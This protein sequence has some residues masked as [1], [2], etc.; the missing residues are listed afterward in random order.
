MQADGII[1]HG[2]QFTY[3]ARKIVGGE[4][5]CQFSG[6][7]RLLLAERLGRLLQK[8]VKEEGDV[9]FSLPE[10]RQMNMVGTKPVIEIPPELPP[11]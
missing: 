8:M 2:L 6:R 9:P 3:I 10:R 4:E 11:P 1:D 7:G 5:L